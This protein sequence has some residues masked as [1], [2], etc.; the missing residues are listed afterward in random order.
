MQAGRAGRG[1]SNWRLVSL[2][3]VVGQLMSRLVFFPSELVHVAS[4]PN[5]AQRRQS[6]H[7]D[8]VARP[9]S[10]GR[11]VTK[12][13]SSCCQSI[14]G[15]KSS[16]AS[17]IPVALSRQLHV[18]MCH[19][20]VAIAP[21]RPDQLVHTARKLG[22]HMNTTRMPLYLYVCIS[23]LQCGSA[24]SSGQAYSCWCHVK[25]AHTCLLSADNHSEGAVLQETAD[26]HCK[27]PSQRLSHNCIS[28]ALY[29]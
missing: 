20:N 24:A 23:G 18:A 12:R 27:L 16:T 17:E 5:V 9:S 28:C 8:K 10:R 21:S 19:W 29:T 13:L 22:H 15:I 2:D 25:Y 11:V 26:K 3:S 6:F 7:V 4:M 14:N 1:Q